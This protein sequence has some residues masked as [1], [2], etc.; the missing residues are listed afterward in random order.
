MDFTTC[1]DDNF[2]LLFGMTYN[3]ETV[4]NTTINCY[5]LID[6][7]NKLCDISRISDV[8]MTCIMPDVPSGPIIHRIIYTQSEYDLRFGLFIALLCYFII[9]LIP[10]CFYGIRYMY[11][12]LRQF[13]YVSV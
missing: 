11:R 1:L 8:S 4:P 10:I 2:V 7:S 9:T 5:N 6:C 3:R 13:N 12:N